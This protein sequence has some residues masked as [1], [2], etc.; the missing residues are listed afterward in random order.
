[1]LGKPKAKA[2][3]KP[4]GNRPVFDAKSGKMV[5]V[6]MYDRLAMSPGARIEGPAIIVEAGTS[7]YVTATFDASIDAG[8]GLVLTARK[9][10]AK[11]KPAAKTAAK[12]G[13]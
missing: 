5:K 3:P 12:K 7:T 4:I 11:S 13:K 8:H 6:P 2:G 1:M 9:A 10:G